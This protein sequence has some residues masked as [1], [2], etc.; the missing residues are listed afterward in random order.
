MI[1][2]AVQNFLARLANWP[3]GQP[4]VICGATAEDEYGNSITGRREF[5][6]AHHEKEYAGCLEVWR[7]R[8]ELQAKQARA[9]RSDYFSLDT[10]EDDGE[11]DGSDFPDDR[12]FYRDYRSYIS[13][14]EWEIRA[15]AIK[16]AVG[17]KCERCGNR[18]DRKTLH[19]H[20]KHYR[21]L[22]K[23][24]RNDLEVLCPI[25]HKQEHDRRNQRRK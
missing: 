1:R 23:E 24:R 13:S 15:S 18:G 17:W 8:Q 5:V 14:R 20:H 19:V 21:T 11:E 2:Q 6:H 22:Y 9:A 4:C 25:C 7:Y 10:S 3:A 16:Q 12:D